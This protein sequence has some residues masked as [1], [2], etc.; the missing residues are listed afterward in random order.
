VYIMCSPNKGALYTGVTSNLQERVWKHRI[1]FYPNSF[2]SKYNCVLLVWYM[3][4]DS[5]DAAIAEEKR[6]K[7]TSR[8]AKEALVNKDNPEWRDLWDEI[9]NKTLY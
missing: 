3:Y 1:K 4:F 7:S 9:K 8:A 5:I 6:I 2:T